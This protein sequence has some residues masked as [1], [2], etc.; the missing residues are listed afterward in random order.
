MTDK[1][2]LTEALKKYFGFDTFKGDQEVIIR[3]V[4]E[5]RDT[6]VLMPTGGGKSLCYQLPS[7][8]MDG[9]AIVISPLIALMKN[10]VDFI[11]HLS[12]QEGTA[13][14]LNSS[15]NKAAIDQVKSDIKSGT[16]KLL[17]VAPESLTKEDNVEFLKTCRISFYAID[18]AHCISEWGH[19]FRPEYRRIRPIINEIGNAPVIALTATA[20][21]K[22]RTDIKKNLGIVNADEFKSSFNRPNLYYEVRP[23]TK[24]I[25]K[26]I[27]RFIKQHPGKSG[28][29]Y[30]L[31][32]KKVEDLAEVLR[33]NDIKAQC[34][35]AGLDSST[36]SQ[37]QDD[38][39]ME[40]IDVIVATIAFGM[41]IDKPDVRF[42]IH[43]DIPKSL[44]GYYQET[45]RAGRD[46]GEGLC[47][48]FYSYKDLQKL[49]KFMEGKPVA[50]Q[51]IGRQLL[52]ETAAYAETSVCRRK[53]LLHYFGE[54][55]DKDNC[56]NCDNCLHPGSKIEAKKQ[57]VIVLNAILAVKENFRSDYIIDFL[58]GRDTDEIVAHKH[59]EL[60]EFGAG[61]DE[62]PKIWNPI[63]RQALI[64]GYLKKEVENYGLLKVT[65][66]GKRF[67]KN[68]QSFM[69]VKDHE[70]NE[71]EEAMTA[72]GGTSALDPT[73]SAMLHDLRKKWSR[74]LERPPYVIF[75]DVSLEQMATDYPVTL[76]EL[77]NIQGVGDGKTRQPYAKEFVDLIK[78]YCEEHEIERQSDL[79]VRTK[80]KDS[81]RKLKILQNIDRRIALD[82]IANALGIDFEELL[83]ELEGIVLYSGNKINIDYFLNEIMGPD[84]VADICDFFTG[85]ENDDLEAAYDE[86]GSDFSEDE[87]RL[88]RI[89]FISDMAN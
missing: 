39:L 66:A 48:A 56:G 10:Q 40:R 23:K 47:I 34:Y 51:D 62:E 58:M 5:G 33:A 45:G 14:F 9:V 15:L 1:K 89:K 31:S 71:D 68:P 65:A 64:A 17:Y 80:A 24:D 2:N 85:Q 84:D 57:L 78:R 46:G 86:F 61:E 11:S 25:D 12:E 69:V 6:F 87:I 37:T 16:T 44:E 77:K 26:D 32:R 50:E 52:Q 60:E 35:H 67:I 3:N 29:I 55:Y 72:E 41:G 76:E 21:D 43:Y 42:V 79:R 88:V 8:L 38:F 36:R 70:F 83:D 73:L 27:V 59:Q 74:K 22:V 49:D 20:T 81:M 54:E 63:I 18:E 82:D 28:I 13:H 7:L 30:C 53:M 19:D 4:L 75:Q